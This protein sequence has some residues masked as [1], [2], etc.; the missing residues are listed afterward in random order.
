MSRINVLILGS[1]GSIGTQALE[2]IRA[3]P[4]VF[5][6]AGLSAHS[7]TGLLAEQIEEFQPDVAVI[8][9]AGRLKKLKSGL[10]GAVG[11]TELLE[12]YDELLGLCTSLNYDILLNAL[13]GFS[14]FVPTVKALH[15]GKKVALANK[16]SLVVGGELL[17]GYTVNGIKDLIPVDSEHSAILQCLI[18]EEQNPI[19]KLLITASGGPFRTW[20]A[21]KMKD[22]TVEDALKHPN[23]NMGSKITIDSATMMNK[24]LEIIEAFWLYNL[25]LDKIEAV[26]HPQSIIHSMVTFA[27]GSTKAQM[28]Y[29]DMKVPIQYALTWPRRITLDTPRMDFAELSSLTFEPVDYQRFPCLR[30]ALEAIEAGGFSPA[31]LNAA[32]E[33]A[34]HRF[35]NKDIS[36][37]RI[38]EIVS[39]CLE[40]ISTPD[41]LGVDTLKAID[42]ETRQRAARA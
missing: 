4:E 29:P 21:D 42:E 14:G 17:A 32:N 27:D 19:E 24:G 1:T 16:E 15:A 31:I 30:L 26:V 41:V 23:W 22:I 3:N 11:K 34:V 20:S 37:I 6:V 12:G 5:R 8:T 33:V 38:P 9:S 10:N 40:E 36:Y 25:P 7:N 2:I 39:G 18:G 13:V 35:L 28:G